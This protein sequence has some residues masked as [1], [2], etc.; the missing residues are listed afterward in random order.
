MN[1]R[2]AILARIGAF[3]DWLDFQLGCDGPIEGSF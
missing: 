1:M 3:L 2:Q